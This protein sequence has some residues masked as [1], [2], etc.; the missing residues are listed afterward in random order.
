M[1]HCSSFGRSTTFNGWFG[2][3][4]GAVLGLDSARSVS[5]RSDLNLGQTTVQSTQSWFGSTQSTLRVDWSKLVNRSRRWSTVNC[6]VK[7][8]QTR[9][10][11]YHSCTLANVRFWNDTTES[12]Y[13]SFAQEYQGCIFKTMERLE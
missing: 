7:T 6:L 13:A 4:L 8:S 2:S 11:E 12:R 10:L 5:Q 9:D 3:G 1:R